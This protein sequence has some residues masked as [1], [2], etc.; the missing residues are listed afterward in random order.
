MKY[1]PKGQ[2]PKCE[3]QLKRLT[4]T[5]L[6]KHGEKV[7]FKNPHKQMKAPYV[8]YADLNYFAE[9]DRRLRT[10]KRQKLHSKNKDALA[11]R[12]CL[13]NCQKRRKLLGPAQYR[14]EDV[15][16][17]FFSFFV[18]IY[19][20]ATFSMLLAQVCTTK[21][22]HVSCSH[23]NSLQCSTLLGWLRCLKE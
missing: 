19:F 4:R 8:I 23:Q 6:P 21:N 11:M 7:A 16:Y 1:L 3:G 14:G 18:H 12:V 17:V 2:K 5:E 10:A 9:K 15:V 13:Q 20:L 22:S